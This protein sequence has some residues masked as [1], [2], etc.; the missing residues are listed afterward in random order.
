MGYGLGSWD[1][2]PGRSKRFFL[3][4]TVSRPAL[5]PTQPP[6]QWVLQA[7]VPKIKQPGR[8]ADHSPPPAAEIKNSGAI[9]PL[10][11]ISS[12]HSA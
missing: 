11:H 8:E 1:S 6:V 12:W 7:L 10:P 3:Y 9:P 4:S 2:I 5:E